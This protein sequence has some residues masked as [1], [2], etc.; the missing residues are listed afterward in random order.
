[1]EPLNS[2]PTKPEVTV[3]SLRE[4][5][6]GL[7]TLFHAQLVA[8]IVLSGSVSVYMLRQVSIV[9]RQVAEM[10]QFVNDYETNTKPKMESF[11]AKLQQFTKTNPDFAPILNKFNPNAPVTAP[12][13]AA[14][15][16]APAGAPAPK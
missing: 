15:A 9:R 16:G 8:L 3:E 10:S 6:H 7:R 1:M 4:S 11:L 2:D 13:G 12:A 5:V 14:P